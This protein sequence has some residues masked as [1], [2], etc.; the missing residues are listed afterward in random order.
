M[1]VKYPFYSIIFTLILACPATGTLAAEKGAVIKKCQDETGKW[2]YGDTAAAECARS[3]IIEMS[4]R[5]TTRKEIAAPPTA[6][7][8][9]ERERHKDE[10]EKQRKSEE[11]QGRKDQLLLSTYGHEKDI[12]YVRDRKIAQLEATI[13]ASEETLKSLRAVLGRMEKQAADE[14]KKGG[15][16]SD[17]TAKGLANSKDQVERHEAAI[18]ARKKEQ[19]EVHNQYAID[20][21]RYRELK[22]QQT[23]EA[24]Q[25]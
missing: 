9:A 20:L 25:K 11:E 17:Q 23:R 21:K 13:K 8:L 22:A 18:A 6:E 14:Q 15:K 7:E 16:V 24:V 12:Q 3:K 10:L 1:P 4:D 2:H 19:E 5:G